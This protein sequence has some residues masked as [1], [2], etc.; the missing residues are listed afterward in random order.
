MRVF[1]ITGGSGSGKSTVSAMLAEMGVYII[2]TDKIARQ[3]VEKGS[4]CL[5]ELCSA[6]GAE[7]LKPDGSLDRKRL[8]SIAFADKEKTALLSRITHKYIKAETERLIANSAAELIGIDGAVL[9]GSGI[10]LLCETT[11]SVTADL[12]TCVKRITERDNLT[13]EEARTRLSAQP[14]VDYYIEKTEYHIFN[15]GDID[16]LKQQVRELINKLKGV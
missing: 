7:I 4:E 11:V 14:T 15:N 2:D 8:A 16:E 1:G 12:S 5:T 3:V 9:I 13:E 6:F 10:D